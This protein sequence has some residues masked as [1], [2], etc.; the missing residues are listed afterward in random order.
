MADG[1][2]LLT[3]PSRLPSV[4]DVDVPV[5]LRH[6]DGCVCV[7][8]EVVGGRAG[9]CVAIVLPQRPDFLREVRLF[10]ESLV[11]VF[12]EGVGIPGQAI[13][14]ARVGGKIRG[15][16]ISVQLVSDS[17]GDLLDDAGGL[18]A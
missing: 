13:R 10:L 6:H 17:R 11:Q 16:R 3:P 9:G 8:V 12:G 1:D 2:A 5:V 14:V 15:M 18:R 7:A 4:T